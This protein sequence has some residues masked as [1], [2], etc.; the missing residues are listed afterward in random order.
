MKDY[1]LDVKEDVVGYKLVKILNYFLNSV[2][3][4]QL[5]DVILTIQLLVIAKIFNRLLMDAILLDL[6]VIYL[7]KA[8]M[9]CFSP[10]DLS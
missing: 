10:Y 2:K 3:Y 4:N 6:M 1:T 9:N 8:N 7:I 5:K